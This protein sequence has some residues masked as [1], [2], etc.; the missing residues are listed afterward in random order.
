MNRASSNTKENI[1][2][3]RPLTKR[4]KEILQYLCRGL[5]YKEIAEALFINIE[6]VKSHIKMIYAKLN[7][8][9]RSEAMLRYLNL[10]I[11]S[12]S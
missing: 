2:K 9:N 8:N 3:G 1:Y 5:Q 4:E 11:I 7:V 6:T 10:N 12:Q